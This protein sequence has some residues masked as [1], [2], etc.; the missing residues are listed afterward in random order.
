LNQ[1]WL[2]PIPQTDSAKIIT[3]K[4]KRLR[5]GLR[6]KQ[7]TMSSLKTVITSTKF[8]AQFLE[9]LEE[10]RDLSL[11]EWYFRCILRTKLLS[12]LEQ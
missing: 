6:D 3:A 11:P 12:L 5:K 1:A 8:L 7:A 9:T 4:F 10:Y 2:P